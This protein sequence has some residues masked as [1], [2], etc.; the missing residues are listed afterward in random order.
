MD[1]FFF[2]Y[3]DIF[4]YRCKQAL[5]FTHGPETAKETNDHHQASRTKKDVDSWGE[6]R[7]RSASFAFTWWCSSQSGHWVAAWPNLSCLKRVQ[8]EVKKSWCA[9]LA[10]GKCRRKSAPTFC[11]YLSDYSPPPKM[12]EDKWNRNKQCTGI[13]LLHCN[14]FQ[15]WKYGGIL[16]IVFTGVEIISSKW[17]T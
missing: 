5:G 14:C 17:C 1:N 3:V 4:F 8:F 11:P 2:Y 9:C 13:I 7:C 12:H 16:D 10:A 6:S 15:I